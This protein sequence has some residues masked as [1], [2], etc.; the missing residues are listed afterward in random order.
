[1]VAI[2]MVS[3]KLATVGLLKLKIFEIKVMTSQI[4]S[5][6]SPAKFYHMTQIIL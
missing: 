4:M 6:S 2:L 1:M 3:A 5:M